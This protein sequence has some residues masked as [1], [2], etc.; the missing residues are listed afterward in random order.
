V[1]NLE[2]A[3]TG[4]TAV[5]GWTLG[6]TFPGDQK[7]TNAWNAVVTQSGEA[8]TATNESYNASISPGGNTSLG[9]QGTWT[10][11]DSPPTA[12]TLNGVAC[13]G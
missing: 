1:A 3:N 7:V 2:I 11:S 13:S 5:N 12:F 8:A 9:F 10:N 6:F 4:T